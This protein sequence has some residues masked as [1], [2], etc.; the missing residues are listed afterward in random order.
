MT[1]RGS[2]RLV[3]LEGI[4]GVGKTRLSRALVRALNARPGIRAIRYED[5]EK[6]A[7]GFNVLKPFI[8]TSVPIAASL[9]FYLSSAIDKS[10]RI[11]E[12]LKTQWVVCDRY[13]YSTFAFHAV[14]GVKVRS[15]IRLRALPIR[16][17]DH[18][19]LV[20]VSE[21][22]RLQRLRQ[23]PGNTPAD[24]VRKRPDNRVGKFERVL[25]AWR[26]TV[27]DNSGDVTT[28]VASLLRSI[29]QP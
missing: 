17:P 11:A 4:D 10:R 5:T 25:R 15:L 23:R 19:F 16:W 12:L 14:H 21:D 22:V 18:Y 29:R 8:R 27:V 13:V 7:A 3:V 6:R 1:R 24:R 9:L 28:T 26:P 2:N 20:T